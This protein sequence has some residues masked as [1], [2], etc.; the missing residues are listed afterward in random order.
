[1]N[2]NRINIDKIRYS[3][4]VMCLNLGRL[5]E[6]FRSVQKIGI[7]E[8]HFDIMDGTFVPNLTLGFDFIPLAKR[9]CTLPCWAHLMIERPERYIERL[10]DIGCAGI[11]LHVES[12]R[13]IH[14]AVKKIRELGLSSGVAINPM[15][16]LDDLEYLLPEVDRV[17]IMSV[18]PGYAGQ[19]IIPQSFERVQILSRKIQY[20]QYPVD[21]EIDGNITIKNCARFAR[22]GANIFILGSSSIFFGTT[23]NY[24]ESFPHF[25]KEVAE[26]IHLV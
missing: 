25:K 4:S 21:I 17:L 16:P 3:A 8:L 5:E 9:C 7:D 20:H 6:E 19:K 12:C 26:Q 13:H 2:Q 23:R 11:T 18:D 15:T 1:M 14:R 24:E 22:L 10:A